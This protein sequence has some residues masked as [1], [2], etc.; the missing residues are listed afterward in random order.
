VTPNTIA[1]VID[2]EFGAKLAIVGKG[3][4]VWF[5]GTESNQ[6]KFYDSSSISTSDRY[7][8]WTAG[9]TSATPLQ[10]LGLMIEAAIDHHG[11]LSRI[12][13]YG[14]V[15]AEEASSVLSGFGYQLSHRA[16]EELTFSIA[17]SLLPYHLAAAT[18]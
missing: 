2:Q 11:K 16:P 8:V 12:V 18:R 7:T 6:A 10:L 3:A 14:D 17:T 1:I 9:L 15:S 5:V 13:V 4:F